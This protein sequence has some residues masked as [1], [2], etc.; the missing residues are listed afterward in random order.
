MKLDD[1]RSMIIMKTT[2]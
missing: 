1:F 2:W